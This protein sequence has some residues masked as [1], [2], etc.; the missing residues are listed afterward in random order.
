[1]MKLLVWGGTL[2]KFRN[3]GY[4]L[5]FLFVCDGISSRSLEGTLL[6][7]RKKEYENAMNFL[8]P[9]SSKILNYPDNKLD[10]VAFLEIVK[11]IE[12]F[13]EEKKPDMLFTHF[14]EDLNIDHRIVSQAAIT[15]V[16]P[17]SNTFVKKV[18][19]F[20]VA[21]STDWNMGKI[22]F[23]PN[24]YVDITQFIDQKIEYLKNYQSEMRAPPHARSYENLVALSNIRG[25]EIFTKNAEAF[26]MIREYIE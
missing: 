12:T 6:E 2:L 8:N 3:L 14:G 20:E 18:L 11:E 10:T 24:Y 22:R 21:S 9:T 15:A 19:Q 7:R 4:K 26:Y 17:G 25:A 13:L 5:H 23:N 16:R 1:M